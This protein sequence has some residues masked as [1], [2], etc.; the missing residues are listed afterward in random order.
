[1]RIYAEKSHQGDNLRAGSVWKVRLSMSNPNEV[2]CGIDEVRHGDLVQRLGGGMIG[3]EA[4]VVVGAADA[5]CLGHRDMRDVS[6][7]VGG[8]VDAGTST[9][10]AEVV[11]ENGGS[12]EGRKESRRR[13]N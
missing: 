2:V 10:G 6:T 3:V 7:A 8:V 9:E 4:S 5:W 1:M 12:D 11:V 13:L